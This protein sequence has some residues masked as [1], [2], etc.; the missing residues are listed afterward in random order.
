MSNYTWPVAIDEAYTHD[1][2]LLSRSR[3]IRV[4]LYEKAALGSQLLFV[5]NQ[6]VDVESLNAWFR[7]D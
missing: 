6:R 7:G 4:R 3:P 5:P 2:T 1:W